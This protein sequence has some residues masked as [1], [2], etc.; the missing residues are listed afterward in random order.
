MTAP[1]SAAP[2]IEAAEGLHGCIRSSHAGSV[3]PAPS[4]PEPGAPNRELTRHA[5]GRNRRCR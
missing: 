3:L 2:E 5:P 1:D 4:S